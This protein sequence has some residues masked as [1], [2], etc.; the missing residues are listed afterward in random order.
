MLFFLQFFFSFCNKYSHRQIDMMLISTLV[1]LS[2]GGDCVNCGVS[3]TALR[4]EVEVLKR[5]LLD[6][7]VAIVQLEAQMA[8]DRP[9][10]FP[11]GQDSIE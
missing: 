9:E 6:R 2:L 5:R 1:P 7:D 10:H 3:T 8:Q 11:Q 4:S